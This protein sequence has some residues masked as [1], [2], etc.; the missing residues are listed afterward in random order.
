M[1][2]I[3]ARLASCSTQFQELGIQY[4]MDLQADPRHLQMVFAMSRLPAPEHLSSLEKV[5][6]RRLRAELLSMQALF[7]I[8]ILLGERAAST[9][10]GK[11]KQSP[12]FSYELLKAGKYQ[13]QSTHRAF[14]QLFGN[15][16]P[17]PIVDC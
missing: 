15:R 17:C 3:E 10:I 14:K 8:D 9:A 7:R 5:D 2:T 12:G 11:Q 6:N 13:R 4:E 1:G 16:A